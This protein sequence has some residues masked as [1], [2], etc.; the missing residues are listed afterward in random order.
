MKNSLNKNLIERYSRQIVLKNVGIAGQKAI[1]NSKVLIVGAGGL[2]C[3]IV[4]YLSRAGVGTIGIADHDKV[5]LSNIHRQSLY[6]SKDVGKFKV[7]VLKEKIKSINPLIKIKIFKKKITYKNLNSI[8]KSFDIIIDGSDNF[9][10]K[11]L[12]NEYS[13]KY[14]KILIVGA[15]SKFD[16]H[17]FTFNFKNQNIPCLKCFYQSKP[18]DEILNCE[19]EGIMGPVAG[20]IGNIQANEVLKKILSIGSN[21]DG[22]ILII[23]LLKF[24]F[25]KVSYSKKK[26][27]ICC[28]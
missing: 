24:N 14:K 16:G 4:D 13:I 19:A 11:F 6:S 26:N 2:G 15:I 1:I 7:N 18:S 10:T 5:C 21:L 25:K 28:K 8:I 17:V 9:K 20:I 3:P 27:C 22:S 23:N 12:L